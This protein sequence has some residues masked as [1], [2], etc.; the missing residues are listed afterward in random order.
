MHALDISHATS[1]FDTDPFE[2]QPIGVDTIF[3][4][5]VNGHPSNKGYVELPYTL[6]QDHC[7][8]VMMRERDIDVW[9]MKLDWIAVHGG[10]ALLNTHPDYMKFD[11][12][13]LGMEEYPKEY[14]EEFLRYV[15]KEYAGE[16]WHVLPSTLADFWRTNMVHAG[17]SH[18]KK[19]P[20]GAASALPA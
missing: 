18:Q 12:G 1:S 15:Q 4:F 11:R 13:G 7:L 17:I 2:P 3:P 14:Y 9:K 20:L 10:M 16:Y 19:K 6:P 5:W 8:Y